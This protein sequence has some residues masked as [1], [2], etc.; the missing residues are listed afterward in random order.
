MV[1]EFILFTTVNLMFWH[2]YIDSDSLI[3][4]EWTS[5]AG[6]SLQCS[7]EIKLWLITIQDIVKKWMEIILTALTIFHFF[8][9]RQNTGSYTR[10][11]AWATLFNSRGAWAGLEREMA[12]RSVGR[13]PENRSF[14]MDNC[15]KHMAEFINY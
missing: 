10:W 7:Y 13:S 14:I 1:I 11:G 6:S 4:L 5:I 8:P 9:S 2:L 15:E 3:S 12:P